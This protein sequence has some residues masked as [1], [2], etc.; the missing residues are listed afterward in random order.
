MRTL[1][2]MLAS[3]LSLVSLSSFAAADVLYVRASA[4]GGGNGQSW[5]TAFRSLQDAFNQARS[6]PQVDQI[7]VASGTYKPHASNRNIAFVPRSNLALYGGFAGTETSIAQR[8]AGSNVTTLSG[9]LQGNDGSGFVRRTDNSRHVVTVDTFAGVTIDGFTIAAGNADFAGE[10]YL[11]GGALYI[12]GSTATVSNCVFRDNIAGGTAPDLGGFGGALLLRGG[13]TTVKN[14]RFEANRGMNGG[15]LGIV[16]FEPDRTEID[17]VVSMTSCDFISNFSPSQTGGAIYSATGSPLFGGVVGRITARECNFIDNTAEYY[18]AW[19]DYNAPELLVE[20]CVFRGNSSVAHGGAFATGWTAG[21]ES[22]IPATLRRCVFE[23]NELL[24]DY[25]GSAVFA[26]A[27]SVLMEHCTVRNNIGQTC[28]RS[29]PVIGFSA[30]SKNLTLVNCLVHDNT[31]T[32]VFAFR[33]PQLRVISST[34]ARNVSGVTG[35]LAGGIETSAG[36]IQVTNSILW[37]NRRGGIMDEQA[38]LRAFDTP[39]QLNFSIV[40]GLT[41]LLGGTGNLGADPRFIAPL[42]GNFRLGPDSP[43]ID[44][45]SNSAVPIG[46]VADLA[47]ASRFINDPTRPDT[48][49]GIGP[50]V[51]IG[52]YERR[53]IVNGSAV[54]A[55]PTRVTSTP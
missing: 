6:T 24:N 32:G 42:A 20:D 19:T 36:F 54:A 47:R 1:K 34:I 9:D 53:L 51:D 16:G 31:G 37:N 45:G 39:I 38:Q 25:D 17:T 44:A 22:S 48:G 18:G 46:I 8:I 35:G 27:R 52:V 28:I 26:Q 21:P 13:T 55:P 10:A 40:Q 4:P 49:A 15:A 50:I 23:N 12:R 5:A 30:G 41:G 11:G 7:W 2:L 14:C 3:S 43:A 33:N 29:G